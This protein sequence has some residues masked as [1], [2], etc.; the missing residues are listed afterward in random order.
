MGDRG[1]CRVL[2]PNY[3]ITN[4]LMFVYID[5]DF[6]TVT[7]EWNEFYSQMKEHKYKLLQ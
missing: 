3:D 2:I 5:E 1:R 4:P 7:T 6:G